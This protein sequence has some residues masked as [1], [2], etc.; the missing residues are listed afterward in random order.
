MDKGIVMT[1]GFTLKGLDRLLCEETG[2]PVHIAENPIDC[3]SWV[4]VKPSKAYNQKS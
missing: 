2:M 3:V 4:Q 1:G